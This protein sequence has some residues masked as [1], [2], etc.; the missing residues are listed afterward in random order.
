VLLAARPTPNSAPPV[1]PTTSK[2]KAVQELI[3]QRRQVASTTET[4]LRQL[5]E[6]LLADVEFVAQE[7]EGVEEL[8]SR[9]ATLLVQLQVG[10]TECCSLLVAEMCWAAGAA[11][12]PGTHCLL[13]AV[14]CLL[15][16]GRAL[17]HM[18]VAPPA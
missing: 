4:K 9:Q 13:T 12:Q 2:A 14:A 15:V 18:H 1:A 17:K 8:K 7:R 10:S 6:L 16:H 11:V 3:N 5:E